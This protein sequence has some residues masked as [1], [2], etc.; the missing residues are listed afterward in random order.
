M[1][2]DTNY[3]GIMEYR[4]SWAP[5]ILASA[6]LGVESETFSSIPLNDTAL[7]LVGLH[8]GQGPPQ[9][10]VAGTIPLHCLRCYS[11]AHTPGVIR[12]VHYGVG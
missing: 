10:F 2:E 6:V 3:E 12:R 4:E 5:K 1:S 8:S 9:G 7:S 11:L